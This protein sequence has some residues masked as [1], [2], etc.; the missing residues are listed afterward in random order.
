MRRALA[1][2]LLAHAVLPVAAGASTPGQGAIRT[3]PVNT[4]LAASLAARAIIA[5]K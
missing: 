3:A 5:A 2:L 4:D 1:S